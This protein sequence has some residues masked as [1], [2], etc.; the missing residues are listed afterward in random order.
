MFKRPTLLLIA[1]VL[2]ASSLRSQETS[3]MSVRGV[4]GFDNPQ[5]ALRKLV[6]AKHGGATNKFCVVGYKDAGGAT[7][8]WVHWAEGNALIW[9]EPTKDGTVSLAHSRRYL[10][11]RRDVVASES[12]LKGSTYL[13]T[14]PWVDHI[15]SDC[16]A[17]GD[18]YIIR[19]TGP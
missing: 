5:S 14:R 11:L 13:V 4:K 15:L 6:D 18:K 19:K 12:D 3:P 1:L 7:T 9:W 10:N 16:K 2:A 17:A 8:A